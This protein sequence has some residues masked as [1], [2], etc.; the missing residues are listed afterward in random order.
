MNVKKNQEDCIISVSLRTAF[1]GTSEI[2]SGIRMLAWP[3]VTLHW[4]WTCGNCGLWAECP[5]WGKN[6]Q[7][8]SADLLAT[9]WLPRHDKHKVVKLWPPSANEQSAREQSAE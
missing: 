6:S 5:G 4:V 1:L 7:Q 2:I 8:L 3:T 9:C